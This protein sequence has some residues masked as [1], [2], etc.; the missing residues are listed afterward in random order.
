MFVVNNSPPR[1]YE[2]HYFRIV[3]K[4]V[5]PIVDFLEY[6]L[7]GSWHAPVSVPWTFDGFQSGV[8]FFGWGDVC[9]VDVVD[10]ATSY[11]ERTSNNVDFMSRR[12]NGWIRRHDEE[13]WSM[14]MMDDKQE[15]FPRGSESTQA[16][17]KV[18][19]VPP[20]FT[21]NP[22]YDFP[23]GKLPGL[24]TSRFDSMHNIKLISV[25]FYLAETVNLGQFP[26]LASVRFNA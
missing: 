11:I 5:Q 16:N 13:L 1:L 10:I 2:N 20:L 4:L 23:G 9:V 25:H 19:T 14:M 18:C 24:C 15:R 6:N 26:A 8:Y 7:T 3:V 22:T 17:T 21:Y 12:E